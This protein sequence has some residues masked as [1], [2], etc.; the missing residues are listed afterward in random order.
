MPLYRLLILPL[1]SSTQ[2]WCVAAAEGAAVPE[3]HLA[4]CCRSLSE[5]T[6]VGEALPSL[7]ASAGRAKDTHFSMS[8]YCSGKVGSLR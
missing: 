3:V 2:D 5:M 4:W 6:L 7:L 1:R 8:L